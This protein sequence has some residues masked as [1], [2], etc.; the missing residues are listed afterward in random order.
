MSY[1]TTVPKIVYCPYLKMK[2]L[3]TGKYT[4]EGNDYKAVFSYATCSVV[5]NSQ[6]PSYKQDENTKYL[7][8]PHGGHCEL[9][10]KFEEGINLQ[11]YGL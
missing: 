7:K 2:V 10:D 4:L 11:K 5:E 1:Y 8:C 6:K 9:I 3:L